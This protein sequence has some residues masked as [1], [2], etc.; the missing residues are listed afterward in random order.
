M[1]FL[2]VKGIGIVVTNIELARRYFDFLEK[3]CRVKVK[4]PILVENFKKL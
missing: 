1:I 3:K 4:N 2:I